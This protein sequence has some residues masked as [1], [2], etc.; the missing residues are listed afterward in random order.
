VRI[1]FRGAD[2]AGDEAF[3]AAEPSPVIPFFPVARARREQLAMARTDDAFDLTAPGLAHFHDGFDDRALSGPK[4]DQAMRLWRLGRWLGAQTTRRPRSLQI[5][6]DW[7]VAIDRRVVQIDEAG[8]IRDL[9]PQPSGQGTRL[10]SLTCWG[11]R[12]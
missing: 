12:R 3:Q 5:I 10:T 1:H 2:Q 8:G 9:S 6:D 7:T 4:D 11:R